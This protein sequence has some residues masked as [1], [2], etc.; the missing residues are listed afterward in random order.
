MTRCY[1]K[2]RY[3]FPAYT[4][5][6]RLA[7]CD[8]I[9]FEAALSPTGRLDNKGCRPYTQGLQSNFWAAI[10][11][12][13]QM[14]VDHRTNITKISFGEGKYQGSVGCTLCYTFAVPFINIPCLIS[15]SISGSIGHIH[16]PH[17]ELE[18][19]WS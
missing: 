1:V 11:N 9:I 8:A 17:V 5:N 15:F 3:P 12:G 7:A 6:R 4:R 19:K 2:Q 10:L 13:V 14:I 18:R 16:H